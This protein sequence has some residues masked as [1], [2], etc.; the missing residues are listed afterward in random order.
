M[1][2]SAIAFLSCLST[3]CR[4]KT[5]LNESWIQSDM[6]IFFLPCQKHWTLNPEWP[7]ALDLPTA[8]LLPPSKIHGQWGERIRKGKVFLM[9][10]IFGISYSALIQYK[11]NLRR[12][13][14]WTCKMLKMVSR[15]PL[16]H[17]WCS[18]GVIKCFC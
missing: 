17:R 6:L 4:C 3:W 5:I 9:R 13:E 12:A 16:E 18:V 15:W 2:G 14:A 10:I 11:S 7:G 1:L 8:P